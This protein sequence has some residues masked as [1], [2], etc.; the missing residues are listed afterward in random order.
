MNPPSVIDIC[1][2]D[3]QKYIQFGGC[4]NIMNVELSNG[5]PIQCC[6]SLYNGG[7]WWKHQVSNFNELVGPPSI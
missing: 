4:T 3:N 2:K 1:F 7:F 5:R 6:M